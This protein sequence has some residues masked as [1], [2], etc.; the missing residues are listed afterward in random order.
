MPCRERD[1]R[2]RSLGTCGGRSEA[3]LRW[4]PRASRI[5][6]SVRALRGHGW[7]LLARMTV[8]ASTISATRSLR[9]ASPTL[10]LLGRAGYA[11]KGIV[12]VTMGML[13]ARAAMGAGG[14]ATDSRGALHA[15][16]DGPVGA[17]AHVVI[18][19][20]L[21]RYLTWRLVAAITDAEGKRDEP[22]K[23]AVRAA[24]AA[25]GLAYGA[26]GVQALRLLV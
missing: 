21:L 19:V 13:A 17:T 14:R 16:G 1:T 23:L 9:A 22:T 15:M 2:R 4:V 6:R 5:A 8:S 12:Y 18:G 11:A 26:L 25:R 10:V 24:Q 20:G 7:C 3:A